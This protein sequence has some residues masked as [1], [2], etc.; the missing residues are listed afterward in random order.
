MKNLRKK[1][2]TATNNQFQ[3]Q[4]LSDALLTQVAGGNVKEKYIIKH[5]PW[6]AIARPLLNLIP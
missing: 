3:A 5:L 6:R 1:Q 2:T 4:T